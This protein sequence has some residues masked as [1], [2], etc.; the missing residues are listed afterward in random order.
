VARDQRNEDKREDGCEAHC[1]QPAVESLETEKRL[2]GTEM[3]VGWKEDSRKK[4]AHIKQP[5]RHQGVLRNF[6]TELRY[7]GTVQGT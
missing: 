4:T 3:V 6:V 1:G 7:T 2:E 5:S